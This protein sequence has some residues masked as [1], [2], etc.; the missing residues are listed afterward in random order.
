MEFP[1]QSHNNIVMDRTGI[2][3]I[4]N[5][6]DGKSNTNHIFQKAPAKKVSFSSHTEATADT[7]ISIIEEQLEYGYD[8]DEKEEDEDEDYD[9]DDDDD[10]DEEEDDLM[11]TTTDS[12]TTTVTTATATTTT[13]SASKER[14]RKIRWSGRVRVQEIRHLNN[15]PEYEKEAVWMSPVDYK[16]I[17]HMAKTTVFMMM[18]SQSGFGEH[19][20]SQSITEDNN[21]DFCTR[22]L[23]FR[24]RA[25][26]KIRNQNKLRA[27]SAVLNEQDLQRDEG[28]YDPQFIAMASMD[29]SFECREEA[30]KRA[31][32]DAQSIRSYVCDDNDNGNVV[33][34]EVRVLLF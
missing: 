3:T 34:R 32:G 13:T 18:N 12:P 28:F 8:Y 17:K 21:P 22:G 33:R 1:N 26:S 7:G 10:D 30:R 2:G 23:E 29:E 31:E 20:Q 25:G 6:S 9:D 5:V 19:E 4:M 14:R 15:I 24:T 11:I 16:M 27:R